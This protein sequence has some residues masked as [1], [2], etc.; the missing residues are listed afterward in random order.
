MRLD[1]LLSK[2]LEE[3][4]YV[5]YC[6]VIKAVKSLI[7]TAGGDAVKGHTRTHPEHDG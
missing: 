1:H 4:R 7:T 3:V 5:V 2:D 6:L